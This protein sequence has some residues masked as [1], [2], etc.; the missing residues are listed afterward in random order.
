MASI[1]KISFTAML[2]LVVIIWERQH[3]KIDIFIVLAKRKAQPSRSLTADQSIRFRYTN[4]KIALLLIFEILKLLALFCVCTGQF[5]S[6]GVGNSKYLFSRNV[7]HLEPFPDYESF[8][9]Y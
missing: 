5:V 7:A 3:E 2:Q 6:D 1:F 4:I 9:S 8:A